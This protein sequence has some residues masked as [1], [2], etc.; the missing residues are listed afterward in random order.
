MVWKKLPQYGPGCWNWLR[1]KVVAMVAKVDICLADTIL[2]RGINKSKEFPFLRD[3]KT[4][5]MVCKRGPWFP[6]NSVT[7]LDK[8]K[9]HSSHLFSPR[10]A[11]FIFVTHRRML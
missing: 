2:I 9:T 10:A 7:T 1:T 5:E 3:K 11:S 8:G 6:Q 4:L